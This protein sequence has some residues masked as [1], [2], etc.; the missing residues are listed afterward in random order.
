MSAN[1]LLKEQGYAATSHPYS[2]YP[3]FH[4]YLSAVF[5]FNPVNNP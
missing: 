4:Q 5:G 1:L 2:G 3:V